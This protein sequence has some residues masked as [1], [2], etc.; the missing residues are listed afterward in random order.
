VSPDDALPTAREHRLELYLYCS[1]CEAFAY[2]REYHGEP[3]MRWATQDER[4]PGIFFTRYELTLQRA[5][6]VPDERLGVL[7]GYEP[8][9]FASRT[10]LHDQNATSVVLH[11][12]EERKVFLDEISVAEEGRGHGVIMMRHLCAWAD[13]H[14]LAI[15][16]TVS[17]I[18]KKSAAEL[19]RFYRRNGFRSHGRDVDMVRNPHGLWFPWRRRCR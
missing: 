12:F 18:G 4:C 10:S 14:H 19:I 8:S 9:D 17:P 5:R 11:T 7:A 3:C 2:G 15:F 6:K 13:Q 16:L 1:V